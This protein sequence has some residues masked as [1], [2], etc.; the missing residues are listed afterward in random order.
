MGANDMTTA[1]LSLARTE[2]QHAKRDLSSILAPIERR[3]LIWMATRL[4]GWINADHLTA[5]ALVAMVAAGASYWLASIT[6]IG[7]WL[8]TISLAVNWFGDSLDGTVSRVRQQQR[9]R[10][11]FFVDHVVDA[12]GTTCLLAGL[13]LSS[14]MHPGI[15][16]ALLAAYL[17]V[18]VQVFLAT[19]C[20]GTFTMNFFKIGP[21]EL[22]LM[23]A[24]G[25]VALLWR[26][27]PVVFGH[28]IAL[29]DLGGLIGA[30]GLVLTFV[31]SA[32]GNTRRLYQAEPLPPRV[33][34]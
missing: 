29:F 14:Y 28:S 16:A 7:L 15:A 12:A 27:E 11:G 31:I 5:L 18:C 30:T 26:P 24:I 13:G 4:P 1:E 6:P 23:L 2:F 9:P 22:R 34:A 20:L 32:I 17:L 33:H 21:T 3:C 10:Y 8:A 19:Y 25:N